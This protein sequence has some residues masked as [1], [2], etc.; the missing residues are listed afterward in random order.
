VQGVGFKI[1]GMQY[2]LFAKNTGVFRRRN[3]I[4][5]FYLPMERVG[6]PF[7]CESQAFHWLAVLFGPSESPKG[8]IRTSDEKT[9]TKTDAMGNTTKTA[10]HMWVSDG[11]FRCRRDLLQ[12]VTLNALLQS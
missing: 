7:F 10:Y 5:R 9:K 11:V 4:S 3:P 2:S 6:S 8:K 12:I 1:E